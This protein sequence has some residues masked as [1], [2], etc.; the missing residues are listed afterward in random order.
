MIWFTSSS[1]YMN[2]SSV[3]LVILLLN[4]VLPDESRASHCGGRMILYLRARSEFVSIITSHSQRLLPTIGRTRDAVRGSST[5]TNTI[6]RGII[7]EIMSMPFISLTNNCGQL[8]CGH[9]VAAKPDRMAANTKGLFITALYLFFAKLR[10]LFSKKTAV[11]H[12]N[13]LF[14][15]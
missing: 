14:S 11:I 12:S 2:E 13:S 10:T 3:P 5:E 4:T 6:F 8:F 1:K 7:P 15:L 9:N